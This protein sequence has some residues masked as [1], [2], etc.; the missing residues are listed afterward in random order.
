MLSLIA[1]SSSGHW[2]Q[3]ASRACRWAT[4]PSP[5]RRTHEEHI[6]AESLG[7]SGAVPFPE[8][9]RRSGG[10]SGFQHIEKLADHGHALRDFLDPDPEPGIHV[11]RGPRRHLELDVA[12]RG[13]GE[14][15]ARIE[16][17][18]RGAANISACR[19]LLDVFRP[20]RRRSFERGLGARAI[21]R[22]RGPRR[23]TTPQP[24]P[25]GRGWHR[26][27]HRP[28]R[29]RFHR[30]RCGPSSSGARSMRPPCSGC[31]RG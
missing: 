26:P 17:P 11:A 13:V 18:A 4:L 7:D 10:R 25:A 2:N 8:R 1:V 15:L 3:D 16:L 14:G 28:D 23:R 21:D 5:S 6:A 12:V 27:R 22:R 31:P 19:E 30:G 24:D 29:K 9:R 20:R